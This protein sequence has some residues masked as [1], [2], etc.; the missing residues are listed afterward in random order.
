MKTYQRGAVFTTVAFLLPLIMV[1]TG[2]VVDFGNLYMHHSRL[3]NAAD[4]AAVA[5]GYAY[6]GS[7]DTPDNHPYTNDA[8]DEYTRKNHPKADE[9]DY[10]YQVREAE[11]KYTYFKVTLWENVPLYFLRYLPFIDNEVEI[12][13]VGC[14]RFRRGSS[15]ADDNGSGVFDNL[16]TMGNNFGSVNSIQNPDNYN[17]YQYKNNCSTYDGDMVYTSKSNYESGKDNIYLRGA[18]FGE[19]GNSSITVNQAKNRDLLNPVQ[20]DGTIDITK[21]YHNAVE[22]MLA[23]DSTYKITDQNQQ[24]ASSYS[25]SSLSDQGVDVIYYNIPNLNFNLTEAISGSSDDPLYIICDN[26]NNFNTSANMLN[27]RPIVL[28]YLG[29]SS[30]W[31]N[32]S[33]G[34]FTGNIYAPFGSVNVNDNRF[35]FYGSVVAGQNIQLQSQGYYIQKNYVGS[36]PVEGKSE[37]RLVDSNETQWE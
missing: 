9:L 22:K 31:I 24:N 4:S 19:D 29:N 35:I 18:A 5:G 37:I 21:Y 10:L 7:E 17:I 23:S 30:I 13:A 14:V 16:F 11:T 25:L 36:S 33:G 1:F 8:A 12:S 26:I 2:L 27:G 28:I 34:T 15:S 32:C 3:Q 6:V 20:Y